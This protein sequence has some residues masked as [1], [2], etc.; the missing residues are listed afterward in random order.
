MVKKNLTQELLNDAARRGGRYLESLG[1]RRVG[2]QAQ[3]VERLKQLETPL[4]DGALDPAAVLAEL[5]EIGSPATVA[6]AGGRYFG[7]VI[8]GSLP[9][10]AEGSVQET[11]LWIDAHGCWSGTD[12]DNGMRVESAGLRIH[13]EN[14]DAV[15]RTDRNVDVVGHRCS[16]SQ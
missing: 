15:L 10:A 7:F 1:K 4:Q 16:L 9:A 5:D 12:G 6:S 14:V 11:L 8:G 2:P 13:G 3:A